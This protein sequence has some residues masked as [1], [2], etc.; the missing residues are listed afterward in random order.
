MAPTPVMDI[1]GRALWSMTAPLNSPR[2]IAVEDWQDAAASFVLVRGFAAGV[3][4]HQDQAVQI[5]TRRQSRHAACTAA[6][7][8]HAA[9]ARKPSWHDSCLLNHS[10]TDSALPQQSVQRVS[11][12]RLSCRGFSSATHSGGSLATGL[13]ASRFFYSGFHTFL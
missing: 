11:I 2:I 5:T 1:V 4:A 12:R 10:R 8:E 3:T 7:T 6:R 9:A 13:A